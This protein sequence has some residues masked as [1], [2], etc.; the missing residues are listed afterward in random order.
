M[1][2]YNPGTLNYGT[3]Y[4]WKI[5]AWDSNS[6]PRN[7]PLWNFK[8]NSLPNQPS[9]PSPLNGSTGVLITTN[10]TWTGTDPDGDT[11]TF[12]VYFG[13]SSNPTIVAHNLTTALYNPPGDLQ[14]NTTYYWWIKSWDIYNAARSGPLWHFTTGGPVDDPPYMPSCPSPGDG[15]TNVS[16]DV[17]LSWIGGDPNPGDIVAYWVYF[18]TSNP[19]PLLSINQT[20]TSFD[21]GTLASFTT[22]YWRIKSWDDQGL[23]TLGPLWHFKTKYYNRPPYEPNNPDPMDNAIQVPINTDLC[24]TGGDPDNGD[25]VKYDVYFGTSL[26]LMKIKS[27]ITGTTCFINDLNYS[28][29]YLW[30]VVAWDN[31]G[32]RT[33]GPLWSFTTI[34]DVTPPSIGIT[35]PRQGWAYFSFF[36]GTIHKKFPILVLTFIFGHIT[37]I[38]TAS[39]SQS[40]MDRVEFYVDDVLQHTDKIGENSQYTWDWFKYVPLFPYELKVIA[41]DKCGLHSQWKLPVWKLL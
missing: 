28:Q 3:R 21:P 41:Y 15:A 32:G 34:L 23:S 38:A 8:T 2:S 1:T 31:N 13:L 7:G 33:P 12:D 4:Y 19:P 20:E 30:Q 10:L 14:Y 36:G 35:Q 27:N 25:T 24:W 6:G 17:D 39:D 9:N 29:E 16:L 22:Y 26:P 40:G 11:V 18:G 5:T 37:V